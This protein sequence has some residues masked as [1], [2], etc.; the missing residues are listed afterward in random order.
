MPVEKYRK[1]NNISIMN[2]QVREQKLNE[3]NIQKNT[4]HYNFIDLMLKL[5][6][7]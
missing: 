7:I 4:I 5:T 3:K 1:I 6:E 2:E